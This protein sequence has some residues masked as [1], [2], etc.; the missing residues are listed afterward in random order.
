[1]EIKEYLKYREDLLEESKNENDFVTEGNFLTTIIPSMLDAKLVDSEDFTDTYFDS[2]ID[3]SHLKINGYIV[4]ESGERLQLFLLNEGS[5]RLDQGELEVS[6]KEYY[7]GFFKKATSFVNKA[8]KGH[9]NDIHDVGEINALIRQMSSSS[10]TEQFDVIEVFLV[11][12]TATVS[13]NGPFTQPKRMDFKDE[14]IRIKYSKNKVSHQKEILIVRRLIDLNFLYNVLI[15]KG[16]R[17]ALVINFQEDFNHRVEAIRAA[18]EVNFESFLCVLPASILSELYK[19]FSSRL[20]E[21]NVRSFLQFKKDSTNSGMRVT[22]LKDPEKFIAYNNGLTITASNKEIEVVNDKIYIKS[23]SD[24]QIVNGGQTT[25][26]IYFSQKD[27]IDI[28]KVRVMAKINV[29]KDVS[30]KDLDELISNI[31][32]FSNS[33]SRVS[34]VDLKSTNPQINRIKAISDSVMTP[35]GRKW[36]FEKSK[37]DFN[38]KLRIAGPSGKTRVE[39]EYPKEFRF[40]KEQLGKF[41]RAWGIEPFNV[42][43][44][45]EKVF[46]NFIEDIS[47][48]DGRQKV[49]IDRDFYEVVIA[50]IILFKAMENLHGAGKNAVGQ[51][52][53]AVVPYSISVLYALTD[54]NKKNPNNFDLSR[55]WVKEGLDD[56]LSV[57]LKEMM[58]LMN[59]LIKKYSKSDDLG[60][61]SKKKELWDDIFHSTEI[62]LFAES[63]NTLKILS[64]YSISKK[65][66][67]RR[68]KA[69]SKNNTE[70]DFKFLR[71]SIDLH[72][73]TSDFFK[74][75]N[76][77]LWDYLKENER[78]KLGTISGLIQQKDDLPYEL[79]EF[80]GNLISKIRG[81]HPE[82]FDQINCQE[83]KVLLDT[84]NFILKKYNH[85]KDT[86]EDLLSTFDKIGLLARAKGL[87]FDSVF[88]EMAKMLKQNKA[89]GVKQIYYASA[90]VATLS[91]L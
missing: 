58:I 31:S 35:S 14:V 28:S 64:K 69:K 37:G 79:V 88:T 71:D 72:S 62:K 75:I 55:I 8:I 41:Y 26:T 12:A 6:I 30:E 83:N 43:K 63:D 61:Y 73:K 86:D 82:V 24:F 50:R 84:F 42:K 39:K 59:Q 19:R 87:K 45:G 74:K 85:V 44:G 70:V 66:L 18:D 16:S 60:E 4:N 25:A 56:D 40:T 89:P 21:K 22:L 13:N 29:A 78:N 2:I 81:D 20:L 77:I 1:M 48:D 80:A 15:S 54:G 65:E 11:S 5:I 46:R 10:G 7:D 32:D 47:P 17:E 68:A 38:T 53:A 67:E 49:I 3:G 33:Q 91:I 27:G 52:R 9:L 34:K 23:L 57:Y 90:Y 36:F 76:L 51:M